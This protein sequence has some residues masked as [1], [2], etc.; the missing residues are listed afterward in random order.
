MLLFR[1]EFDHI[2]QAI[3]T[4]LR[5]GRSKE[6]GRV[7]EEGQ[8]ST[9]VFFKL[10]A[11]LAVLFDEVPLVDDDD[12]AFARF[13]DVACDFRILFGNAF[14]RIDDQDGNVRPIDGPQSPDDAVPFDRHVDF[15]LAAHAGRIDEDEVRSFIRP[16]R[17]DRVAGRAGHV[18]DDDPILS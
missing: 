17:I 5:K 1:Y 11:R 4:L 15:G 9:D 10:M 12:A 14:R 6:D 8:F 13:V 7:L 16:M 3:D 18:A 2:G